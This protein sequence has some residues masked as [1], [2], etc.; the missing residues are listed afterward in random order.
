LKRNSRK[1]E[2]EDIMKKSRL[3]YERMIETLTTLYLEH[4]DI[5]KYRDKAKMK[6]NTLMSEYSIYYNL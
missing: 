2:S 4:F 5:A 6:L 1:A 3:Y